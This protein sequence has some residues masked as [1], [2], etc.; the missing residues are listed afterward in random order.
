MD[1]VVHLPQ[2]MLRAA[3]DRREAEAHPLVQDLANT[4]LT[5]PAVGADHHEVDRRVRF[6]ARMR[7]QRI[8]ELGLVDTARLRLEH[9]A[10][11]R[12]LA[13]FVAHRVQQRQHGLLGL[14]LI[15]RQ[16]LFTELDFRVRQLFD[17]LEHSLARRAWRQ[18]GDDE[19]PLTT[20]HLFDLPA[21]THLQAAASA[22]I[23]RRNLGLTRNDLPAA[24]EVRAGNP[25]HQRRVA[26]LRIADHRNRRARD[27]AQVVRRNFR[28]KPDRDARRAVQQKERQTRGQQLRLFER[29]VVVRHEID[30]ALVDFVEQKFRD[31]REAGFGV[32]H[33]R[34][35][36][37]V[38]RA[39]ISLAVDQRI[40]HRKVLR[41]THERVIRRL[42]AVRVVFAQHVAD[43]AR[44]LHRLGAGRKPHGLH[45]EQ[46]AAL[47]GL[48]PI[49]HV[50]QRPAFDH[51]H[52]IVEI[53][54]LS[55]IAER[56]FFAFG[57]GF[58]VREVIVCD[59]HQISSVLALDCVFRW[60][61]GSSGSFNTV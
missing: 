21:R 5:R 29:A 22:F 51:A 33:R 36:V 25:V 20:R 37:A 48:L 2:P 45:R 44:G 23:S 34:C 7:E 40:A 55:V 11:R 47:H 56:Q 26:D 61:L 8:D 16:R 50:G 17:F 46:D 35:A 60:R 13:R 54:A 9:E 31:R 58:L 39:K 49:R 12:V 27:F 4:L 28:S 6:Q 15:L 3:R 18:L 30:G 10:H 32:A 57:R 59:S 1:P 42:V 19:L 52:R 43:D 53:R 38:A 24:R 14:Q 41:E